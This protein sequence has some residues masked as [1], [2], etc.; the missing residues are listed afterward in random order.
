MK[1]Y[2]IAFFF[3]FAIN[4]YAQDA[5]FPLTIGDKW[6]Y[7][8]IDPGH[9]TYNV[10]YKVTSDT[11]M[12]NGRKYSVYTQT[13]DGT[14]KVWYP[15]Y[16]R[17]EA[18]KVFLYNTSDSIE[19]LMYDFSRNVGDTVGHYVAGEMFDVIL[20]ATGVGTF[21]GVQRRTWSFGHV[22]INCID[23]SKSTFLVDSIGLFQYYLD[24]GPFY[25]GGASISGK[26]YGTLN[27]VSR[28]LTERPRE[29]YLYQ[30]YPNP[31]NG[32]TTISYSLP[33]TVDVDLELFDLLGRRLAVLVHQRQNSGNH[34]FVLD[35][36]TRA[37]GIYLVRLT[38]GRASMTRSIIVLK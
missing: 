8:L 17:Q 31:F 30:N 21:W 22:R 16:L 2:C 38:T 26:I 29:P 13:K 4:L 23:G 9:P 10:E 37:S 5:Y 33:N 35:T 20:A 19:Y 32:S 25:F 11:I 18:N 7:S 24:L 14:N 1:L 6:Q 36:E 15:S 28:Q 12:P 34:S 27:D 3:T